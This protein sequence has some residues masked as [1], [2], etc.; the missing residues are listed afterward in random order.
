[1]GEGKYEAYS[2]GQFEFS[3]L[4]REKEDE[5]YGLMRTETPLKDLVPDE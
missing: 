5:V 2:A 3:Q 1:M 4:S